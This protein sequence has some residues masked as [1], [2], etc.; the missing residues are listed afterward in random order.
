MSGKLKL[1][2]ALV[3]AA[4]VVILIVAASTG[5][6]SRDPA[7]MA[8]EALAAYRK[9]HAAAAAR[10]A[11]AFFDLCDSPAQ[12]QMAKAAEKLAALEFATQGKIKPG[13]ARAMESALAAELGIT[14]DQATTGNHN[15]D[16]RRTY[17]LLLLE[18][19][20]TARMM[21][22]SG[23]ESCAQAQPLSAEIVP[24]GTA[25]I[26]LQSAGAKLT[27]SMI[28]KEARWVL[29]GVYQALQPARKRKP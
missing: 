3:V 5:L 12:S 16:A 10:D 7:V 8:D 28:R 22:E 11:A 17:F 19:S 18:K 4:I 14:P 2:I 15:R 9:V 24:D 26:H 13:N 25:L 29:T 1:T 6:F 27:R 21:F 23:L 20:S